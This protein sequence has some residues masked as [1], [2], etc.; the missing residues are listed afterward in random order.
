MP[1]IHKIKIP[2]LGMAVDEATLAVVVMNSSAVI[3][4][5]PGNDMPRRWPRQ[6]IANK[7][8]SP[9]MPARGSQDK[10]EPWLYDQTNTA[11]IKLP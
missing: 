7:A 3:N 1:L 5:H 9:K 4:S 8:M 2:K 11:S 10:G 6:A